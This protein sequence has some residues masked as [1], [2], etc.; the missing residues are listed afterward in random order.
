VFSTAR[1]RRPSY[2]AADRTAAEGWLAAHR[3][4][5]AVLEDVTTDEVAAAAIEGR[6]A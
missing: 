1:A 4:P 5:G 2:L 6:A 3:H